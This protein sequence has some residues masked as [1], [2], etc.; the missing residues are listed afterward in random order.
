[1]AS[2]KQRRAA[3]LAVKG[4]S[5]LRQYRPDRIVTF[6]LGAKGNYTRIAEAASRHDMD[7][8]FREVG[9]VMRTIVPDE[10]RQTTAPAK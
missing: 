2:K 8:P 5:V 9:E 3:R 4:V 7:L 1:M 10:R 6:D